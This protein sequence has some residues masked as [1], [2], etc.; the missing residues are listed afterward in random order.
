MTKAENILK[1]VREIILTFY[2]KFQILL[3]YCYESEHVMLI[4][5]NNMHNLFSGK[6]HNLTIISAIYQALNHVN[7]GGLTFNTTM[8][9]HVS[10]TV[11][12][13]LLFL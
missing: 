13:G 12:V 1:K 6:I 3:L 2:I 8:L 11:W 10:I 5:K 4:L 9:S 7:V